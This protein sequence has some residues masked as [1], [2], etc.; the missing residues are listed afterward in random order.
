MTDSEIDECLTEIKAILEDV[1]VLKSHGISYEQVCS[2]PQFSNMI[3]LFNYW[4]LYESDPELIKLALYYATNDN[5]DYI[6][7]KISDIWLKKANLEIEQI[8]KEI[9]NSSD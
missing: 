7:E 3:L 2:V 6:N 1:S 9:E 4:G 5:W 8:I